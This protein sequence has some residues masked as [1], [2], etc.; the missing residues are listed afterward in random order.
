MVKLL[1]ML[2]LAVAFSLVSPRDAAA[3]CTDDYMICIAGA[4]LLEE[5]FRTMQDVECA[6]EWTGCVTKKLRFW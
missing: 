1:A 5:P 6:A 2:S 3:S 4:G